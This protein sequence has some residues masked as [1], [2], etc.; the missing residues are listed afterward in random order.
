MGWVISA[1]AEGSGFAQEAATA[2]RDYAFGTL[3]WKTLVSYI[4]PGNARSIA[5]ARR[6]GG[7]EDGAVARPDP[8]DLVYRYTPKNEAA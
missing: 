7:I 5:L 6:L 2:V 8:D 3:R 1:D 4:S